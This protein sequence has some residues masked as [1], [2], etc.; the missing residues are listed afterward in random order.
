MRVL[1]WAVAA[2][3]LPMSLAFAAAPAV[4][5][6][7]SPQAARCT[8]GDAGRYEVTEFVDRSTFVSDGHLV[9]RIDVPQASCYPS[10]RR[11][12][13]DSHLYRIEDPAGDDLMHPS[14]H[15][16]DPTDPARVSSVALQQIDPATLQLAVRTRGRAHAWIVEADKVKRMMTSTKE[17]TASGSL[18]YNDLFFVVFNHAA[19]PTLTITTAD[20][21]LELGPSELD[22]NQLPSWLTEPIAPQQLG[23]STV[24]TLKI[25]GGPGCA[26]GN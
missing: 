14:L 6:P 23:V 26:T 3:C 18:T 22:L 12:Q 5:G 21:T 25:V 1:K 16:D 9:K 20:A 19:L 4:S 11:E 8:A 24:Y 2:W 10:C 17:T 7:A 13:V 15:D